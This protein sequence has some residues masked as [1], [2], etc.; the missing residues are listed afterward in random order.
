M[1]M[2]DITDYQAFE[3]LSIWMRSIQE[4]SPFMLSV[5]LSEQFSNCCIL[6]VVNYFIMNC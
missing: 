1:V 5:D 6:E 3:N 2:Y 4:A